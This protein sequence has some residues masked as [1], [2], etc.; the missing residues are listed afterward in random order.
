MRVYDRN[1]YVFGEELQRFEQE[2]AGFTGTSFCIGTGNGLD[3]LTIAL[4]SLD[5][6]PGAEVI[7]P[8]HTYI[9][10]WLAV[11][12][13]GARIIPVEPDAN[14]LN[15]DPS[16][17]EAVITP[18]TKVIL[19]VH[20]YGQSCDMTAISSIAEKYKLTIIEDNAQAHGARWGDKLTGSFGT[21]NATSFYPTKNLGALGD[22]GA[23]T[24]SDPLKA[25]FVKRYRN[26]G[27][28][29]KNVCTERGV[30]SRLDE[31]QASVLRIK[32][33]YLAEWT[34]ERRR[35]ASLYHK[36][37]KN[38]G[39][40]VLP[41]SRK[42]AYHVYHLYVLR[43]SHRDKLK[44]YLADRGIETM[45][46][47]PTPPHLQKS[48]RDL[49]FKSGHFPLT[50]RTAETILSLPLWPGLTDDEVHRVSECIHAFFRK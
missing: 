35:L 1:Q 13:C 9:A 23:I 19:P 14:T 50:E 43:T 36:S 16:K 29:S 25:E 20:L 42:E 41:V 33:R 48:Y 31:I 15:I 39:D 40:I 12:R 30:N 34:A 7:V 10:T 11:S 18:N 32:L 8:A 46:H 5:L 24:T 45:I 49:N 6:P 3:A 47:Y 37:L 26:Y 22:G 44:T 27:F 4:R 21:I 17:I 2:F 28:E 38:A